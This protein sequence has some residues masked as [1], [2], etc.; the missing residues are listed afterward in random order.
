VAKNLNFMARNK[1]F[2]KE[3]VL[4]KAMETFWQKGFHA[5]SME[6]L[7]GAMHINRASMYDTFGD[8][9]NLYLKSLECYRELN[10]KT[11]AHEVENESSPKEKIRKILRMFANESL[12]DEQ[13][14]G[15]FFTNATLEMLPHDV[16]VSA[17]V[18]DNFEFMNQNL[19]VLIEEAQKIGEIDKQK[20]AKSL[21]DF[22]QCN[23]GGLRVIGKTRPPAKQLYEII[24]NVMSVL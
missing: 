18:C 17:I 2:N 3:V 1:A 13:N 6:D 4:E 20:S 11:I 16:K 9:H 22:I 8:K 5:T 19:L 21:A 24:E 15:C 14:K 12:Q 23:I 7:V 10:K